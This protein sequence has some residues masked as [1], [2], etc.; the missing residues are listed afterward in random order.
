MFVDRAVDCG[1]EIDDGAEDAV[2]QTP[3]SQLGGE[4]LD[5]V[6]P[7]TRRRHK[8]ERPARM[9]SPPSGNLRLLVSGGVGEDDVD[10]LVERQIGLD[11]VQ[12]ADKLLVPMVLQVAP[13]H[14]AVEPV[15]LRERRHRAVAF[16]VTRHRRSPATLEGQPALGPAERLDLALFFDRQHARMRQRGVEADQVVQLLGKRLVVGQLKAR[17]ALRF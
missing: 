17:P 16:I 3:A 8:V 10:D 7:R 5:G 1:L 14:R 11:G 9:L 4:P 12:K 6:V 13:D 15:Q 2:L